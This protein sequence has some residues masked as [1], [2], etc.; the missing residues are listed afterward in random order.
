MRYVLMLCLSMGVLTSS[1]G[2]AED[3]FKVGFAKVDV[4]PQA[5]VPM[6]ARVPS[7]PR[8]TVVRDHSGARTQH[9]GMASTHP[10]PPRRCPACP[11]RHRR[12]APSA[13]KRI[14]VIQM[15]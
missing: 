8:P 13:P 6:C 9:S 14:H 3:V 15:A 2:T 11:N 1:V 10:L 5:P 7:L 4:T 12:T